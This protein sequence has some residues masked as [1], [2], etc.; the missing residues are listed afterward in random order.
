MPALTASIIILLI[1]ILVLIIV[2]KQLLLSMGI[3]V[4]DFID[5]LKAD[6]KIDKIYN[7]SKKYN[8]LSLNDKIMF[9]DESKE[10]FDSF[11]KVPDRLW[12]NEYNKYMDILDQ[13]QK[14]KMENWKNNINEMP[15]K[16][17]FKKRKIKRDFKKVSLNG[18]SIKTKMVNER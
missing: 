5:F 8:S 13:Y 15:S 14:V 3:E 17:N 7:L 2:A 16:D 12:D 6:Q 10:I 1:I 9:L 11:S 4:K 18:N